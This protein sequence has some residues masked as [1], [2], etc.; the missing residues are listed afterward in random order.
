MLVFIYIVVLPCTGELCCRGPW[1]GLRPQVASG[2]TTTNAQ[3]IQTPKTCW[4][5]RTQIFHVSNIA[6]A[7]ILVLW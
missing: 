5:R 4:R 2:S 1:I 3:G 7:V 6:K